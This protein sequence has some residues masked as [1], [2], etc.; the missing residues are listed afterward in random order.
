MFSLFF[1]PYGGKTKVVSEI[2]CLRPRP[3]GK[4]F[5]RAGSKSKKKGA[6]TR[7][8]WYLCC[9]SASFSFNFNYLFKFLLC[10]V[11]FRLG[12]YFACCL[13]VCVFVG[14]LLTYIAESGDL[15]YRSFPFCCGFKEYF[16]YL[17]ERAKSRTARF[18]FAFLVGF[19]K[20]G[21]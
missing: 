1:F 18:A 17:G 12:G 5:R 13:H 6:H 20:S 4:A 16:F 9:L 19:C 15:S 2:H 8:Q 21:I 14:A 11:S 10:R 7:T 3:L